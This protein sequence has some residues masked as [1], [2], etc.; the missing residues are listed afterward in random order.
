MANLSFIREKDMALGD[1]VIFDQNIIKNQNDIAVPTLA[2][3][4]IPADG[5]LGNIQN[6][7][8]IIPKNPTSNSTY[9]F[10]D[11]LDSIVQLAS[12]VDAR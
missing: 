2:R 9:N 5:T 11:K 1:D 7:V 3:K 4:F 12:G 10:M 6:A 8:S